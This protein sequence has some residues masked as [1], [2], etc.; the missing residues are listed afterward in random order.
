MTDWDYDLAQQFVGI[1][2]ADLRE[3]GGDA[4]TLIGEL[5]QADGA[6]GAITACHHALLELRRA[7][8]PPRRI[9]ELVTET[10]R[11]LEAIDPAPTQRYAQARAVID[12]MIDTAED[13]RNLHY[14]ELGARPGGALEVVLYGFLVVLGFVYGMTP[15]EAGQQLSLLLGD[16]GSKQPPAA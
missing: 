11:R 5:R 14:R 4:M 3:D 7:E 1:L 6:A 2:L 16:L 9:G 15:Y 8:L 10:V 12:L 13:E